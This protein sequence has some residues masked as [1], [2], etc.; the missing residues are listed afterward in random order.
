MHIHIQ[1]Q[2]AAG[3][4]NSGA[5]CDNE[6]PDH[7]TKDKDHYNSSEMSIPVLPAPLQDYTNIISTED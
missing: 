1:F 7:L 3:I 5:I 6:S 4:C 2:A